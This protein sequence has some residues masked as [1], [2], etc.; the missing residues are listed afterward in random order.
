MPE[1]RA[2]KYH[3]DRVAETLREEIG[4]MIEGELSDPR[5][6]FAYVSQVLL[7]PGGKSAQIY[8]AVDGGVKEEE[9]TLEGLM[10]ARGYIR[11]ELLERMGVRHVPDLVFHIDR[12]EKMKARIDELLGRVRKRSKT[13]G[14]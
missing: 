2:R 3:Q 13:G 6:S 1:Q 5:I 8:V 14:D 12:S 9:E 10:A 4:A 11:H 7:N